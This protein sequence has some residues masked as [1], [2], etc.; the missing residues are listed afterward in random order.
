MRMYRNH[1]LWL[2]PFSLAW[3]LSLCSLAIGAP[4][5]VGSYLFKIYKKFVF[6]K[7]A[8]LPSSISHFSIFSTTTSSALTFSTSIDVC[9]LWEI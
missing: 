8:A 1:F 3:S 4:T 6:L 2:E 9:S 7:R 5:N